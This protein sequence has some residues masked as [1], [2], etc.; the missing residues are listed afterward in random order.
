[1]V[2]GKSDRDAE[3]RFDLGV[4]TLVVHE[5]QGVTDKWDVG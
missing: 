1:V 2:G 5:K 4:T 3:I